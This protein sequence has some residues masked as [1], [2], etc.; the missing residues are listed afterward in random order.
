MLDTP[1]QLL[2]VKY[3]LIYFSWRTKFSTPFFVRQSEEIVLRQNQYDHLRSNYDKSNSSTVFPTY[4]DINIEHP[5]VHYE[6][7]NAEP[8]ERDV[9]NRNELIMSFDF[10]GTYDEWDQPIA[11][12]Y[13]V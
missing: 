6:T 5:D 8:N 4:Q 11:S 12:R 13:S 1:G 3:K 7:I 9:D 10:D 2:E